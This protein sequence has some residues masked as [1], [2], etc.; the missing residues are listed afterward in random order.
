MA[1][2]ED[3]EEFAKKLAVYQ[4]SIFGD[5]SEDSMATVTRSSKVCSATGTATPTG[6]ATGTATTTGANAAGKNATDAKTTVA[7]GN[8]KG[9]MAKVSIMGVLGAGLAAVMA[10]A[11]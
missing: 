6:S 5:G 4:D 7:S 8:S 3:D 10:A 1:T 2:L 11:L 9:S